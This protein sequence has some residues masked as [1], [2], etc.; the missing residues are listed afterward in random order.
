MRCE[1][2]VRVQGDVMTEIVV[3]IMFAPLLI[4]IEIAMMGTVIMWIREIW[5]DWKK[6]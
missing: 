6:C 3:L 4:L 5:R 1:D 2:I